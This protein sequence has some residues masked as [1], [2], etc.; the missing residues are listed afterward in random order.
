MYWKTLISFS[1]AG[2]TQFDIRI[3]IMCVKTGGIIYL[4]ILS[5]IGLELSTTVAMLTSS[6]STVSLISNEV[7]CSN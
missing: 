7:I 4:H 6:S 1:A 2:N 5:N 3:I